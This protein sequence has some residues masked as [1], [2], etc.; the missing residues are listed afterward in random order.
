MGSLIKQW[1]FVFAVVALCFSLIVNGKEDTVEKP[2]KGKFEKLQSLASS[3]LVID[4]D[5]QQF[6]KYV[7]DGAR[8]YSVLVLFTA[9][10]PKY[11]CSVCPGITS[12]FMS[13]ANSYLMY[14]DSDFNSE[15]FLSNPIFIGKLE[16]DSGMEVFQTMKFTTVPHVLL[17]PP[18]TSTAK[19]VFKSE[20][21]MKSG[22]FSDKGISDFIESKAGLKVP[23]YQSP[24]VKYGPYAAAIVGLY[25][26]GRLVRAIYRR[27]YDGIVYFV[28]T[29]IVYFISMAGIV[30]NFIRNPPLY[31]VNPRDGRLHLVMNGARN[32]YVVEG[33]I[34]ATIIVT[35]GLVFVSFSKVV[36]QT[37][38][39]RQTVVFILISVFFIFSLLFMNSLHMIKYHVPAFQIPD[40]LK[41][42]LR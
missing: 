34:A 23:I 42:L 8:N 38:G 21:F 2:K 17:V 35:S 15:K 29:L 4:L 20:W 24:I 32:Q 26:I 3:Q 9:N 10:N 37:T 7:E 39:W 18:S 30:F 6:T 31:D 11:R 36:P 12:E 27:L 14:F 33:I 19:T 25:M 22:D 40:N 1:L 13:F 41:A 28:G 16:P 5:S